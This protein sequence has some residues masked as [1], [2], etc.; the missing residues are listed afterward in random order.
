M[1]RVKSLLFVADL[2][3]SVLY[4]ST[5]HTQVINK[6]PVRNFWYSTTTVTLYHIY[7]IL[8][9]LQMFNISSDEKDDSLLLK[10]SRTARTDSG[11]FANESF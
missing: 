9:S 8:N 5:A 4:V 3:Q 7:Q 11:R 10:H 2:I 6:F 1:L